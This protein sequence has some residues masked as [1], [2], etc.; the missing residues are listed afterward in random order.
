M[1]PRQNNQPVK[2]IKKAERHEI[3]ESARGVGKLERQLEG[4]LRNNEREC[5]EKYI[6]RV[7]DDAK[8]FVHTLPS[9]EMKEKKRSIRE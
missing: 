1:P 5:I 2:K 8:D 3:N 6:R 7:C 4:W 9:D